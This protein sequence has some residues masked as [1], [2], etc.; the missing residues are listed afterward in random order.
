MRTA[1]T[2][3]L[4]FASWLGPRE[5]TPEPGVRDLGSGGDRLL[6]MDAEAGEI[7]SGDADWSRGKFSGCNEEG[8]LLGAIEDAEST[9]RPRPGE[10]VGELGGE[11]CPV[12]FIFPSLTFQA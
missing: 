3:C 11:G 5:L 6:V 7:G 2:S 4:E 1:A 9:E 8:V 12:P 10:E